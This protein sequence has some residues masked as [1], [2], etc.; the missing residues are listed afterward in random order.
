ME[1][2]RRWRAGTTAGRLRNMRVTSL[3]EAARLR[4]KSRWFRLWLRGAKRDRRLAAL[5]LRQ[6]QRKGR[7]VLQ[8][9]FRT[10]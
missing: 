1:C 5:E 10:T 8:G 6:R 7:S 4:C 2:V 3:R 9:W